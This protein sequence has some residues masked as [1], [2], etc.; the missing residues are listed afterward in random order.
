MPTSTPLPSLGKTAET[1]GENAQ[2]WV[3]S[4]GT[5]GMRLQAIAL[6]EA[7]IATDKTNQTSLDDIIIKPSWWLR[8]LPRLV[9][10]L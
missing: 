8:H 6:G 9:P 2:I 1:S 3:I 4:D 7:L 5:A 10:F